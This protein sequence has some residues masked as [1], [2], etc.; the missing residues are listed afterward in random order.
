[1]FLPCLNEEEQQT[2]ITLARASIHHGLETRLPV[3]PKLD[4]YGDELKAVLATFVTLKLMGQLRGCIGS[5]QASQPLV[6]DV[7]QNAFTA[8]FADPRFSPLTVPEFEQVN[9]QVSILSSSETIEC[10]DEASLIKAL[11]PGLD[12]LIVQDGR[13]RATYL[14]SVWETIPDPDMF[15]MHLKAKAGLPSDY[16]S[17]TIQFFRYATLCFGEQ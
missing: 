1:M 8:A 5:L 15:V 7:A 2:L 4:D 9:L 3:V 11:N 16:W 13:Y 14:P 10:T 17:P 12:G 6:L